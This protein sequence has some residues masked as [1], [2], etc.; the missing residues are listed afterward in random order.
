[1]SGFFTQAYTSTCWNNVKNF[2]VG[3][4]SS[5]G[6]A[7]RYGLDGPG[8]ESRW[9]VRFSA[10]VL[11]GPGGHPASYTMGPVSF[12]WVKRPRSGVDHP[13]PSS[14]QVK[15]R[16]ELYLYSPSGPSW[17]VLGWTLPL[18]KN[19]SVLTAVVLSC[20]FLVAIFRGVHTVAKRSVMSVCPSTRKYKRGSR[21][22]DFR[23]IWIWELLQKSVEKFII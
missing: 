15:E 14:A 1:M 12:P 11:T 21:W 13:P 10:I 23:E 18:P 20:V 9:G 16:V 19:F 5:V 3:R 6:I 22:T 17:S 7:T 4:D 8:I 2:S